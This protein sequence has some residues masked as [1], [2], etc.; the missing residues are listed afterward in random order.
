MP[1]PS[2]TVHRVHFEDHD[3][4]DFERLVFAYLLRTERWHTLE[5][6]GQVGS[7]LGRDIW[8]VRDRD[9]HRKPSVCIQCAKRHSVPFRKVVRDIDAAS[10]GP[11]GTPD[12]FLLVTGGSVSAEL[13]DKIKQHAAKKKIEKC[14][15]WSSAEFE[16]RLRKNAESL[17]KRFVQGQVFPDAPAE[18]RRLVKSFPPKRPPPR[19]KPNEPVLSRE[20]L[21]SAELGW[22][23]MTAYVVAIKNVQDAMETTANNVRAR[24]EYRHASGDRLVIDPGGWFLDKPRE[25]TSATSV[26]LSMGGVGRIVL[27]VWDRGTKFFAPNITP[28]SFDVGR[29]LQPGKWKVTVSV[30][31]DN[32]RPLQF[33]ME[34][35]FP[36]NGG[37]SFS[38]ITKRETPRSR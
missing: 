35:K 10:L 32:C 38:P 29:Q 28:T 27:L 31:G 33:A 3:P 9:K 24:V 37:L 21:G 23:S 1:K 8:G 11:N 4:R 19:R 30:R 22:C 34:I 26:F 13:R 36:L 15:V 18:I 17:L 20:G 2:S 25:L 7:D 5:W 16:E 12:E 6:Y 14:E